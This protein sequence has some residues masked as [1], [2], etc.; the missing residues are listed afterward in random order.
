M[1]YRKTPPHQPQHHLFPFF[2]F[3]IVTRL[4]F[5]KNVVR[6]VVI[7]F[8]VRVGKTFGLFGWVGIYIEPATEVVAIVVIFVGAFFDVAHGIAWDEVS[9]VVGAV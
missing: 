4:G 7:A 1:F 6:V 8:Y 9:D 2:V 3:H 5:Y